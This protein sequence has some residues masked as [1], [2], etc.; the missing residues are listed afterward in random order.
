MN[1]FFK[2]YGSGRNF[3]NNKSFLENKYTVC[4][5]NKDGHISEHDGITDPWRYITKIKKSMDVETAWIKE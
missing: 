2:E 3:F 5:K 4:V 1:N